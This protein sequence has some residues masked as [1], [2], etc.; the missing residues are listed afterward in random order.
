MLLRSLVEPASSGR[1]IV[2][3]KF[4]RFVNNGRKLESLINRI[5]ALTIETLVIQSYLFLLSLL[6]MFLM[7]CLDICEGLLASRT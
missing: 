6:E 1:N 3:L 7:Y 5:S 2:D 4:R